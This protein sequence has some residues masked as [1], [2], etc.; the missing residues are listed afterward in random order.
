ML[1]NNE[2][3]QFVIYTPKYFAEPTDSANVLALVKSYNFAT[4]INILN[5]APLISHLPF[6][7][8]PED[9]EHGTLYAHMA[10]AL[11]GKHAV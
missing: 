3:G 7:Y 1:I 11:I 5:G 2:R 8:V 10:I 9:G 6:H 4:M